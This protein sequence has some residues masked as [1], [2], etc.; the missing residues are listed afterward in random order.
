MW[1]PLLS[2][3]AEMA[4]WISPVTEDLQGTAR[5]AADIARTIANANTM[6]NII[7]TLL[8]ISFTTWFARLAQWLVPEKK[9]PA[10]VIIQPEFLN[11]D[12]LKAPS[13]ALENVR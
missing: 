3:L 5:L 2:L 6:F 4:V 11:K 10:G 13:V 12:A 8:F 7:N 9:L 1:L